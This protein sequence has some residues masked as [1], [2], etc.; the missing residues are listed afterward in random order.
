MAEHTDRLLAHPLFQDITT[1]PNCSIAQAVF[2]AGAFQKA[3]T[4]VGSYKCGGNALWGKSAEGDTA[5]ISKD[6]VEKWKAKYYAEPKGVMPPQMDFT[7]Q[8]AIVEGQ[9]CL[10]ISSPFEII[11]VCVV[12]TNL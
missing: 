10:R 5:P 3:M 12:P 11:G 2:S 4:E 8:Y 1:A 7:F 6:R 9:T